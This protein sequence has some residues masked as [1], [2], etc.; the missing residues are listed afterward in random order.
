MGFAITQLF[1]SGYSHKLV[2]KSVCY[3]HSGTPRK[4]AVFFINWAT[5]STPQATETLILKFHA[6][7]IYRSMRNAFFNSKNSVISRHG[8][9]SKA[10]K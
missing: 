10:V 4:A 5:L 2:K 3:E 7:Y 9:C 1:S 8:L 6:V